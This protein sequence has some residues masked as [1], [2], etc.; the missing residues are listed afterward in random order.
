MIDSRS[1]SSELEIEEDSSD[2]S[3][4]NDTN[5]RQEDENSGKKKGIPL[6]KNVLA[7]LLMAYASLLILFGVMVWFGVNPEKAYNLISVPFVALIGGTLAVAKD[8]I[9]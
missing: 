1:L 5:N 9:S 2:M 6:R 7:V 3:N 4:E 8:I